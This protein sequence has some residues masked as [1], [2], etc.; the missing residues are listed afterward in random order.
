MCLIRIEQL[1]NIHENSALPDGANAVVRAGMVLLAASQA[2]PAVPAISGIPSAFKLLDLTL[3][4]LGWVLTMRSQTSMD[5]KGKS[6][7]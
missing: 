1:I 5:S 3:D 4:V 7:R 2:L 6:V